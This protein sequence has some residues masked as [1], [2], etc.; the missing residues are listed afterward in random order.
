MQVCCGFI[1]ELLDSRQH[2]SRRRHDV[3]CTT[4]GILC[5]EITGSL[6]LRLD[7]GERDKVAYYTSTT[8]QDFQMGNG[9]I[10]IVQ[11]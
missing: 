10:Y 7:T 3:C 5:V 2:R 1:K 8:T 4:A 6:N 11:I 9:G